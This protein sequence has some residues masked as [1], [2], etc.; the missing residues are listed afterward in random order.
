MTTAIRVKG[1]SKEYRL[2]ELRSYKTI[3]ESLIGAFSLPGQRHKSGNGNDVANSDKIWALKDISF[4]VEAGEVVGIIG[5]NGAGKT[6]L[7][8]ILSR[9]TEP[10]AGE[11]ELFGR[12]SSLLEVG[13]G[14]HPELTG[15]EN[16]FLNGSILGMRR[17]E[18]AAKFDEIVDFSGVERFLDTPVKR[19][20]TGMQVRLA[21]AVAAHLEPEI[22]LVDEVLAVGDAEFQ[23][24]CLGKM[25]DIASGGRTIL[26]VS[27]N[28][29]AVENLCSRGLLLEKGQVTE[30]D[31]I[32]N[33]IGQYISGK[34]A[35][36]GQVD[37]SNHPNRV[38]GAKKIIRS[39]RT[40]NSCGK[41]IS[42]I[43]LGEEVTF[44]LHLSSSE[45]IPSVV[46][47]IHIYN[48]IGQRVTTLHTSY[49]TKSTINLKGNVYL[50][51]TIQ[52]FNLAVGPY[53]IVVG[54]ASASGML[55]RID[56]IAS[57]D[58]LPKDI[59]GTGKLPPQHDGVVVFPGIWR[60]E[61]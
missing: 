2:G 19:Y 25:G 39:F 28:M 10:T 32:D 17:R 36:S 54:L 35:F 18:I 44:V 30:N 53:N 47:G 3:R 1:V 38:K 50:F 31:Q 60:V 11:V 40:L 58:I 9:I 51:C 21:F 61:C 12:V 52:N 37:A 48:W 24:K 43:G 49:Q 14:F 13:T 56:P 20:S 23:R 41:D 4:D 7:L 57:F 16:I 33:V 34:S 15:R 22:L 46:A 8:K 55:D 29:A 27:H 45:L 5:H 6:T 59:F 42:Q 26:F